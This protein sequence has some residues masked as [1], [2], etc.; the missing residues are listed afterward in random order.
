MLESNNNNNN[1]NNINNNNYNRNT[2][3]NEIVDLLSDFLGALG[4]PESVPPANHAGL[5]RNEIGQ[6][7]E[8]FRNAV[9]QQHELPENIPDVAQGPA[10]EILD[11]VLACV[12][13]E[14]AMTGI[15]DAFDETMES[16][17]E[18]EAQN[19]G[20]RRKS[21]RKS[22]RKSNTRRRKLNRKKSTLR[23]K[24]RKY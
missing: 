2:V 22:T 5:S 3:Y 7:F 23:R 13:D 24:N 11:Y 20:R 6:L 14:R 19:G 12:N 17:A 9:I 8:Q 15:K 21:K 1:N 16:F 10:Q 18:E 4:D